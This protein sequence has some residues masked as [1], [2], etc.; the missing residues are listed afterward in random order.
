MTTI[1]Q[2]IKSKGPAPTVEQ[3]NAYRITQLVNMYWAPYTMENHL[4][5]DDRVIEDIYM[6]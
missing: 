2:N 5:F 4:P 3:I 1:T 6:K